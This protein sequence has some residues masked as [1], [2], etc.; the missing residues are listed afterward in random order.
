MASDDPLFERL[1]AVV[2]ENLRLRK[3]HEQTIE[4]LRALAEERIVTAET[5]STL[6][7][8]AERRAIEGAI[9]ALRMAR[10]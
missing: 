10:L 4:Q 6:V 8:L 3:A 5:T 1:T 7:A 9:A 2:E